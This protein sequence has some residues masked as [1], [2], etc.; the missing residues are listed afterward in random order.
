LQLLLEARRPP[1]GS[2]RD[3]LLAMPLVSCLFTCD[4]PP[5]RCLRSSSHTRKAAGKGRDVAPIMLAR[6]R[7]TTPCRQAIPIWRWRIH[8]HRRG[9][10]GRN[11][12]RPTD[13]R[14]STIGRSGSQAREIGGEWKCLWRTPS[15]VGP[16]LG[17]WSR[18]FAALSRS[19]P[20]ASGLDERGAV[21]PPP[22]VPFR[23]RTSDSNAVWS[24][25][26]SARPA[27]VRPGRRTQPTPDATGESE[28]ST[29][30]PRSPPGSLTRRR[31]R[32]RTPPSRAMASRKR[33]PRIDCPGRPSHRPRAARR[34]RPFPSSRSPRGSRPPAAD[35]PP[36]RP[37]GI[38]RRR[39]H[40]PWCRRPRHRKACPPAS[41]PRSMSRGGVA[42]PRL[43]H[44]FGA[45]HSTASPP[46][47]APDWQAS[48]RVRA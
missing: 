18:R 33:R 27:H 23:T 6:T 7:L 25:A 41:R 24:R 46:T 45:G 37:A 30:R 22:Q 28:P 19:W 4:H 20:P 48:E 14:E 36:P 42:Q 15:E 17:D 39:R 26:L 21:R 3:G 11:E 9:H 35:T 38:R 12:Q 43:R 40:R 32:S 13:A 31:C 47:Q 5:G 44:A 34:I 29:A 16:G 10:R 1:G 2:C 8:E